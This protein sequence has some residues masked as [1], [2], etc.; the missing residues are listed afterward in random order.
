[1]KGLKTLLTELNGSSLLLSLISSYLLKLMSLIHDHLKTGVRTTSECP[2]MV[3]LFLVIQ[4][5]LLLV[6]RCD[7]SVMLIIC[8]P[9]QVLKVYIWQLVMI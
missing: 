6:T 8:A 1:M 5:G 2:L 7:P 9:R 4:R 3:L